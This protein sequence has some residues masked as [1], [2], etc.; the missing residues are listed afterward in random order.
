[1]GVGEKHSRMRWPW[2]LS[3]FLA[4]LAVVTAQPLDQAPALESQYI[5]ELLHNLLIPSEREGRQIQDDQDEEEAEEVAEVEAAE[6]EGEA[7]EDSEALKEAKKVEVSRFNNYIDAIYRRMNAALK[8][9]LMDPM[10][11]N[12]DEKAKKSEG[13]KGKSEKTRV[14]REAIDED[15]DSEIDV[16]RIGKAAK[17]EKRAGKF[18]GMSK[19]ERLVEKKKR[20]L[21]KQKKNDAKEKK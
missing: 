8:A 2:G 5:T 18:K 17:T 9:K 13:K 14:L 20:K 7:L 3:L 19:E 1:M 12:L 11:L 10:E 4:V 15:D 21:R 16:S 6:G